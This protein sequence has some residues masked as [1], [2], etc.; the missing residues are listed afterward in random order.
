MHG[1]GQKGGSPS[2]TGSNTCFWIY[3][4]CTSYFFYFTW[5][6][7]F[8]LFTLEGSAEQAT[9]SS[10]SSPGTRAMIEEIDANLPSAER[11]Q[12][13]LS[14]LDQKIKNK[15]LFHF[16]KHYLTSFLSFPRPSVFHTFYVYMISE[17]FVTKTVIATDYLSTLCKIQ[18]GQTWHKW[19]SRTDFSL[20]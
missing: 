13:L 14:A 2:A 9:C 1:S 19:T 20:T 3:M 7:C 6:F 8:S 5:L 10:T 18:K 11:K 12:K 4:Q 16:Y 17:R 15:G